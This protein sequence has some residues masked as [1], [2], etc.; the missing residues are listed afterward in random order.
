MQI[1]SK[2]RI[3]F[4]KLSE[5]A[6]PQ[7]NANFVANRQLGAGLV[8]GIVAI[9][10]MG[11]GLT[12]S[13]NHFGTVMEMES[14]N[15][16]LLSLNQIAFTIGDSSLNKGAIQ[17]SAKQKGNEELKNCAPD[18]QDLNKTA[19]LDKAEG[20][21]F[22]YDAG[23][24]NMIA[25]TKAKPAKFDI[26]GMPCYTDAEKNCAFNA[27]ASFKAVCTGTATCN[28]AQSILVSYTV[29]PI[30]NSV[31]WKTAISQDENWMPRPITI[32]KQIDINFQRIWERITIDC[33]TN[34]PNSVL[35]GVNLNLEPIC[36]TVDDPNH[37]PQGSQGQKGKQGPKGPTGPKGDPGS[38]G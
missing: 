23:T 4:H 10:V 28:Q 18:P 32:T 24:S 9:S 1:F 2:A 12:A 8:E 16:S 38:N 11:I 20:E 26:R 36:V 19:C 14:R 29:E 30:A 5:L 37:G 33:S 17:W 35:T 34:G 15:T 22:L 13:I 21:F 3:I 31:I 6:P 7:F 27:T 25:G